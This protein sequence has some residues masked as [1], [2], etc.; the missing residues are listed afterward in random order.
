MNDQ[1]SH[2]FTITTIHENLLNFQ[3]KMAIRV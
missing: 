2:F 3:E 1:S